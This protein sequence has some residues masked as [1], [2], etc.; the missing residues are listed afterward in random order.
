MKLG[1]AA[2]AT[3][4]AGCGS[5]GRVAPPSSRDSAGVTI[6]ESSGPVW[7][8]EGKWR[9]EPKAFLDIGSADGAEPY[10]FNDVETAIRLVDGTIVVANAGS[11]ELRYFDAAGRHLSSV[12]RKGS[13]PGEFGQS[14]V[15]IWHAPNGDIVANDAGN[16]R[17]NIFD[18][19]RVFRTTVTLDLPPTGLRPSLQ[20]ILAD[21]SWLVQ[22]WVEGAQSANGEWRSTSVYH[23]YGS[24]GKHLATLARSPGAVSLAVSEGRMAAYLTVPF[25]PSAFVTTQAN[26]VLLND[27]G[28]PRLI[29][30]AADGAVRSIYRW[31]LPRRKSADLIE[32]YRNAELAQTTDSVWKR[33]RGAFFSRSLPMPEFVPAYARMIVD[34]A[35]NIWLQRYYLDSEKER[36]NDILA[37]D[38]RWLGTVTLPAGLWVLQVGPDFL[39]GWRRDE[40]DVEH[41]VVHR[42]LKGTQ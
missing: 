36:I 14:S 21:G 25:S 4:A 37:P 38:G 20:G 22:A 11:G 23:R 5:G 41:V 18:S 10:L 27:D 2:V 26:T 17:V 28:A 3:V 42:L 8:S 16:R 39:L 24:D 29:Q 32:A 35:G 34:A 12:G 7:G 40:S 30:M 33:L 31:Q 15:H 19:T 6:V 9:V 13:G 1:W